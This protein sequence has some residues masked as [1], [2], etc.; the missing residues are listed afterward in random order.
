MPENPINKLFR[1]GLSEVDFGVMQHAF[2]AHGRDYIFVIQDSLRANPG[3]Y[4]LTFTHVVDLKYETR[5]SDESWRRS[6]AD[7]FTRY[8]AWEAA[9]APDGYVFGT[10]WSLAY[11]GILTPLARPEA[12]SWS[13]RL[14]RPMHAVD[15]GTDRF[16]ISLVF[17][18][19]RLRK[20]ADDAST[21]RR[22]IIPLS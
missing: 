11:P 8:E 20:V 2:A 10:N 4:E 13:R 7:E 21:V 6:W 9:G 16:L 14:G 19:A 18:D 1:E 12:E 5:V 17:S 15:L 3:T 22:V